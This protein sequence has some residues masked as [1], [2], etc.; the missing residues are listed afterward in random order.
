M[1]YTKQNF[2]DGQILK[3]EHLNNMEQGIED[4]SKIVLREKSDTLTWDGNTEGKLSVTVLDDLEDI[5][6][7]A[8]VMMIKIS[9]IVP[10]E[11]DLANGATTTT[12]N[13]TTDSELINAGD[14]GFVTHGGVYIVPRNN[15]VID[16]VTFPEAGIW[17]NHNDI[18]GEKIF[19]TSLTI[20]GYTG[21]VTEKLDPAYLPDVSDIPASWIAALQTSM[22][23]S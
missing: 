22:G 12:N 11:E 14:G 21:F 8:K 3:A 16:G 15:Y 20:P 17:F 23:I 1:A 18:E 13:G 5:E 7:P 9:D 2:E 10:T 6:M 4:V 19:N